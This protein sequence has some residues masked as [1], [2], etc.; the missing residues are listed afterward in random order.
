MVT[1]EKLVLTVPE[2]GELLGVSRA[3]A[4]LMVKRGR[5]PV[6]KLGRRFVV[7]RPALMKMLESAT[8][9][10]PIEK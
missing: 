9:I 8:P 7:P 1:S 3:H 5:L 4:Y 6:I 2:C 10:C